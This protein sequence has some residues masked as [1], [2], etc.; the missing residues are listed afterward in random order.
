MMDRH[1][2]TRYFTRSTACVG[3]GLARVRRLL[4]LIPSVVL[5]A[6]GTGITPGCAAGQLASDRIRSLVD[7]QADDA[8]ATFHE[9]LSLP[10]DGHFPDDIERL[11]AWLENAF[12]ERGFTTERLETPGNP[13][14]LAERRVRG[15]APTVL[16]YLQSDGQPVDPS[17]WFQESP[18]RPTLKRL[19]SDGEWHEIPWTSLEG[20]WDPDWRIFARSA[21]DSKGPNVQFLEA[22]DAL[23]T[24]GV[25]PD[26]HLKVIID[27]ME[28]MGSPHLPGAVERYR[29]E[30]AADM[31]VI[32]DGPPHYSGQPSLKFGARGIARFTLTTYGPRVAQHSGHYGNYAPNPAFRLARLLTSMKDDDGRV[33]IPGF[34]D[35]VELD[36]DTRAILAAVPD[37]EEQIKRSLGIAI[38]DSV[39]GSLQAAVQYPSLNIRGMRSAWVGDEAR[40]IVPPDAVAEVDVRLVRESDPGRLL[41]LIRS[42]IEEQGYHVI[43]GHDP[44][45]EERATHGWIARFDGHVSYQAFRTDFDSTPGLWLRAGFENLYGEEPILIRTSGGSIPISPFVST[46]GIPAVSVPTVNPDNNQH[47][48][49]EN[50]RVGSFIEGIAIVVSVLSQPLRPF[51]T[52]G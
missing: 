21:S 6:A 15:T 9:Y 48:P 3:G 37:D 20:D 32:F 33:T 50:I 5:A 52:V 29:D 40:T 42:H 45:E 26:Y 43:E 4:G 18:Y 31:L 44:T 17:A 41:Q 1:R 13:L 24:E 30:L 36:A 49:N 25:E 11:L 51:V 2:H 47:S 12:G 22:L 46:L 23:A 16:V 28:E 10:N 38:T 8:F 14:L 19:E 27:T 39:A 35:G 34:Y 7:G